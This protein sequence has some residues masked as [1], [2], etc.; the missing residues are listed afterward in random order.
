[1]VS[2]GSGLGIGETGA[3]GEDL[4]GGQEGD[5]RV[6]FGVCLRGGGEEERV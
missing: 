6:G 5:D 2:T 3:E 1:M 4:N